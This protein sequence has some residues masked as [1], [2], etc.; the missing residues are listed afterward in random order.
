MPISAAER[1]VL[2]QLWDHGGGTVREVHAHLQKSGQ[3]WSRS[4]VVTLLQRLEKK[5][6]V[7]ADRRKFA[8]VF[9]PR[10]T[11]EEVMH[12]RL[13]GVATELSDGDPIPLVAAFAEQHQF[14]AEELR[15]L[16][17]LINRLDRNRRQK[18]A[19]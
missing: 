18:G 12:S 15:R 8:F 11:R 17:D 19:P 5:G 1:T 3:D 10:V 14:T 2:C 7:E 6:Y 13:M 4:T 16:R 9:R